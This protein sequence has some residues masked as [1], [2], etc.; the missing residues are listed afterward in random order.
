MYDK[1][2][3]SKNELSLRSQVIYVNIRCIICY[4]RV[5]TFAQVGGKLIEDTNVISDNIKGS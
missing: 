1:H 2:Q 3:T 5:A 4:Q